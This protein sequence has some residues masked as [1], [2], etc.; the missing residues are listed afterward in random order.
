MGGCDYLAWLNYESSRRILFLERAMNGQVNSGQ[1]LT[2]GCTET[3]GT[4]II[5]Q[6]FFSY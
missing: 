5:S 3:N 4:F 2:K 1:Y 6:N